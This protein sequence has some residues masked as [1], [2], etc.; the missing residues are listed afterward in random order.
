MTTV[1]LLQQIGLNKYEAE[2]YYTLLTRGALTGYEV[3][4]Y[5]QVP[6]SRSY[7]ILERLLEKG[8]A[9]VQ[10]GDPPRYAAQNPQNVFARFR[11]SMETT[12]NTLATSLAS[13]AQADT[14]GEFWIVRGQQNILAQMK[15]ML[16][17]VQT[18]L[19]LVLPTHYDISEQLAEAR[20][21]GARIF[22]ASTETRDN[23]I[24]LLMR[25]GRDSLVGTLTPADSCQAVLSSNLALLDA[26]HGYFLHQQS[27]QRAVTEISTGF[28]GIHDVT[29]MD[30]EARKQR[31]LRHVS[32][33]NRTA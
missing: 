23:R 9:F 13:L 19:D 20:A 15:T 4:K 21:R 27:T 16:T 17:D 24:L 25:D 29:W 3:G 33:G 28:P 12:L 7:E 5:S 32:S 11:S 26:L 31:H 10:P 8:L 14:M 1:E 30:W 6:G 2:A 22:H 18:S